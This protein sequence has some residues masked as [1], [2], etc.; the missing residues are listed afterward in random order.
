MPLRLLG[1]WHLVCA[2]AG[3]TRV[4]PVL[5]S[6]VRHPVGLVTLGLVGM[7]AAVGVALFFGHRGVLG[8]AAVL[9][10]AQ[11]LAL[12]VPGLAVWIVRIGVR[13]SL[14]I[15]PVDGRSL[16]G[17]STDATVFTIWG[18][19]ARL[20]LGVSVNLCALVAF[21]LCLSCL[22]SDEGPL[23]RNPA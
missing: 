3:A 19:A 21:A 12:S 17:A 6:A 9:Q 13:V 10:A 2:V 8:M 11:V 16:L 22:P 15:P 7:T 14:S 4:L 18:A 5:S 20:P 1:V 23:R